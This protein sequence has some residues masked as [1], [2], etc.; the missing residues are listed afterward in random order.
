MKHFHTRAG[1]HR[2]LK[3]HH[4]IAVS[5]LLLCLVPALFLPAAAAD[6]EDT[7]PLTIIHTNDFHGY[8]LPYE[9]RKLAPPPGR[10]GGAAYITTIIKR[11][12][13]KNPNRTLVLDAGDIA[14]GTPLSNEFRGIPVVEYMNAIPFDATTLGNHEFDWGQK[15]L[16][17]MRKTMRF[18]CI[19]ANVVNSITGAT[20][21]FVVPYRIFNL[22]GVKVGI[23][24][25]TTP[26][27]PSISY[28]ENIKNLTFLEP[29]EVVEKYVRILQERGVSIIGV[30]SHLGVEDDKKLAARVPGITFITGGHSHTVLK[31]GL[32]VGDTIITQAGAYGMYVGTLSMTV[33]RKTGKAIL[34]SE[35]DLL[36]PVI[37]H[38]EGSVPPDPEVEALVNRYNAQIRSI[39]EEV[40]GTAETDIPKISLPGRGDTPLGNLV[41]DLLQEDTGTEIF[42]HNTGGIRSPIGKGPITKE[43]VYRVLPF[44]DYIITAN[45][46]GEQVREVLTHGI[47]QE[48][49]VQV[50]GLTLVVEGGKGEKRTL[51]DVR[52]ADGSPLAPSRIYRVGTINFLFFGGDGYTTFLHGTNPIYGKSLTRE[53]MYVAVKKRKTIDAPADRRIL[54]EEG[55]QANGE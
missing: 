24:G 16:A 18:P 52:L 39:M 32:R 48:K 8:L 40:L 55:P 47:N 51:K 26:T 7:V 10:V 49:L 22:D 25:V 14:Q 9:D 12:K 13:A 33:N 11:L 28:P 43:A 50:A 29:G 41:T 27:I 38:G 34:A 1:R 37:A 20:P 4:A 42:I 35:K 44:D 3:G 23:I 15:T 21:S 53:I 36:I 17:K 5:C 2:G 19:C 45:L 30:L 6:N 31:E 46:T 54:I